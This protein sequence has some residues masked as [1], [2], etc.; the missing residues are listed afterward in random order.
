M[1]HYMIERVVAG[2]VVERRRLGRSRK[3]DAARAARRAAGTLSRVQAA[4]SIVRLSHTGDG[5]IYDPVAAYRK[6]PRTGR[7]TRI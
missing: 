2:A 4:R 1:K 7:V 3:V 5:V 6:D